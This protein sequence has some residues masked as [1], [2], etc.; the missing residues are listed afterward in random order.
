MHTHPFT[1][2]VR[3]TKGCN[4]DCSYCSS[5][6]ESDLIRMTPDDY[7]KSILFIVS[8]WGK[9]GISVTHLTIEYV[10]GEILLMPPAQ[11]RE[12]VMIGRE[13]FGENGIHV[14]DGAQSNLI[15]SESRIKN[16]YELFDTRVGTSVDQVTDQRTLKGSS[17]KYRVFMMKGEQALSGSPDIKA[18]AVFTM[19]GVSINKT[20]EQIRIS[21]QENRNLTIRPVFQGGSNINAVT[22][23]K[24]GE[25]MEQ[26]LESWLLRQ[27][28]ILEP[29]FSLVKKHLNK[30]HKIQSASN[31]SFC[32]FQ[33]DC[34]TK[35][36]SLE[37]NGDLF[38]CQELG[39]AGHGKIGNA[40]Q[41]EW[42]GIAWRRF[43]RRKVMLDNSCYECKHYDICQGGCMMNSIEDGNGVHGKPE[44][45]TAWKKL[46]SKMDGLISTHGAEKVSSWIKYLEV[47][48]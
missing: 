11:L 43:N 23:E 2:H 46:F 22:S 37:P 48:S 14:H 29:F 7:R 18:P 16:L 35:S 28:I 13:V 26:A 25:V 36:M 41:E 17:S 4:A 27:D 39:D 38:I 6:Q 42:D 44:Y 9:M 10:G 47:R 3:L 5:W 40:I 45:C 33:S 31:T 1:L 30:Y 34:A 21:A 19:D 12:I 15:G 8:A 24:L 32:S 20:Q